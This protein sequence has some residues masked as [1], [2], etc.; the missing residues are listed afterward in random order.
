MCLFLTFAIS[1][2]EIKEL[3][4]LFSDLHLLKKLVFSFV[5]ISYLYPFSINLMIAYLNAL[6]FSFI[7]RIYKDF[8]QFISK[9]F[10]KFFWV[11]PIF[12]IKSSSQSFALSP[13]SFGILIWL[14]NIWLNWENERTSIKFDFLKLNPSF[15]TFFGK[16]P[17]MDCTPLKMKKPQPIKF[18]CFENPEVSP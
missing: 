16:S 13:E 6:F 1:C 12:S 9:C 11:V 2:E 5:W 8:C 3:L 4:I 17:H 15:T 7:H 10:I 14:R 18:F